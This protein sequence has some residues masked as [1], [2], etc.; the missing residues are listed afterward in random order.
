MSHDANP[1]RFAEQATAPCPWLTLLAVAAS[2]A[3]LRFGLVG[4]P[5]DHR[6]ARSHA[7]AASALAAIE[8]R[9][10]R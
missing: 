1:A 3:G 6:S 7:A 9:H 8:D 2:G 10:G 5:A 4:S